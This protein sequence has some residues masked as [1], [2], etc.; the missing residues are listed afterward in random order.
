VSGWD[1]AAYGQRIAGVYD[2]WY[3]GA[4]DVE[5]AVDR[6]AQLAGDGRVLELG[7]GTGRLAIP[8]AQRA[9]RVEGVDLSNEM[10][11]RLRAKPGGEDIPVTMADFADPPVEGPFSLV[12]VAFNTLFG[13]LTQ[14]DQIRCFASARRVLDPGGA[15]L[16]EAFVPDLTR[17]QRHQ[18]VGVEDLAEDSRLVLSQHDPVGQRISSRV[19]SI[20][21]ERLGVYPIEIRYAWPPELDLM[22]EVAGLRLRERTANWRGRPFDHRSTAHISVYEPI[23]EA[24]TT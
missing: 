3:A 18:N 1:P 20:S 2:Q 17:Y 13:L 15:F 10:V 9:V 19:I 8:L 22:A 16:L 11:A 24:T 6:L 21:E 7:I 5:G 12:F 23:G 4:F 14:E